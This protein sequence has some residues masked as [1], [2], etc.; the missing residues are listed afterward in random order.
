MNRENV[1]PWGWVESRNSE[2]RRVYPLMKS[3]CGLALCSALS[4]YQLELKMQI[5][6][7]VEAVC[8]CV[9]GLAGFPELAHKTNKTKKRIF[10]QIDSLLEWIELHLLAFASYLIEVGQHNCPLWS[11]RIEVQIWQNFLW[12]QSIVDHRVHHLQILLHCP[13]SQRV[14]FNGQTL[15]IETY[16]FHS[17]S[18]ITGNLWHSTNPTNLTKLWPRAFHPCDPLAKRQSWRNRLGK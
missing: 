4:L 12:P 15:A 13:V 6:K 5:T 18:P 9:C 10:M 16:K 7:Y 2:T 14:N 1:S 8:V 11:N 3:V 17:N